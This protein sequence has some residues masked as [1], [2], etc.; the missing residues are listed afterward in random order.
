MVENQPLRADNTPMHDRAAARALSAALADPPVVLLPGARQTG[1]T[2]LARALCAKDPSRHYFTLDDAAVLAA[3][4]ADSPGFIAGLPDR[5]VL[6]EVQRVP[7]LLLAIKAEVD[8]RRKAGRF[9]L[10]GAANVLLVPKL[11]DRL[12]GR[13]EIITLW[14]LSQ[15]ELED[16]PE[17]FIDAVFKKELPSLPRERSAGTPIVERILRGGYP[18]AA[19]RATPERR[20]AW[21]ESYI[22]TILQRDVREIAAIEGLSQ[23]PRLLALLASR[24]A[25]LLNFADI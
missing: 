6:D 10:T 21:F 7:D 11:A 3:A 22:T 2:T 25:G 18:E 12:A 20:A 19:S 1:K 14:P 4:T 17:H 8:R 9:L 16:R 24:S 13:M 5:V 23:L 15:G